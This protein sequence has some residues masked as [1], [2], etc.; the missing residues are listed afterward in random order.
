[1]DLRTYPTCII[2]GKRLAATTDRRARVPVPCSCNNNTGKVRICCEKQLK[3]LNCNRIYRRPSRT[4][5]LSRGLVY[6][7]F[8][9]TVCDLQYTRMNFR[10][11]I[12]F[13][14]FGFV[15]DLLRTFKNSSTVVYIPWQHFLIVFVV[16]NSHH[17]RTRE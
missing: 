4:I 7:N 12:C 6:F 8:S 15:F 3:Q 16:V 13:I 1:V 2:V 10:Y 9:S 5:I 11:F 14:T 17:T